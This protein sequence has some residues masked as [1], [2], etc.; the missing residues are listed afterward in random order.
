MIEIVIAFLT[1]LSVGVIAIFILAA[2]K[3]IRIK[4]G[5]LFVLFL[6]L[7]LLIAVIGYHFD[8]EANVNNDLQRFVLDF[9]KLR[10]Y[11]F[12]AELQYSNQFEILYRIIAYFASFLNNFH[13]YP[14]LT[15]VFEYGVY[16]YIL[17]QEAAEFKNQGLGVITCLMFKLALLP[18][19]MSVSGSR[20]TIAYTVFALGVYLREKGKLKG[21]KGFVLI[22]AGGL[23]HYSVYFGIITYIISIA[24]RG[25]EKLI[26]FLALWGSML[27]VLM[28]LFSRLN[29]AFG[30]F[31]FEKVSAYSIEQSRT[32]MMRVKF[33]LPGVILILII[34]FIYLY[35]LKKRLSGGALFVV[36]QLCM[37]AGA[38]VIIP[39]LFIRMCYPTSIL[40]PLLYFDIQSK[41]EKSTRILHG[42]IVMTGLFMFM[43]TRYGWLRELI[44]TVM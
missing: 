3:N 30:V 32:N 13:W 2:I 14:F 23:I 35:L 42:L 29:G 1:S 9:M 22:I 40:F 19:I 26:P 25:R 6:P 10:R 27:G 8:Y 16:V 5:Q 24:L 37:S 11:G 38:A 34:C 18:A 15:L 28:S 7:V 39:T 36:A 20:N 21:I 33:M 31:L 17:S 12:N 44:R 41:G 4:D 43:M